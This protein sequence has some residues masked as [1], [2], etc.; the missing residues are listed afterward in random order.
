[1]KRAWSV[2]RAVFP[3]NQWIPRGESRALR[4]VAQPPACVLADLCRDGAAESRRQLM[5]GYV[6]VLARVI[7]ILANAVAW[8]S[9]FV[10]P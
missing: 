1:M 3:K 9:L 4:S 6:L 7:L 10:C 5:H 8:T 2:T